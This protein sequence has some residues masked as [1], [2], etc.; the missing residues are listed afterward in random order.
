M[1]LFAALVS[2]VASVASAAYHEVPLADIKADSKL[3][4]RLLSKARR[5][6]QEE[7]E[8]NWDEE[9]E[10]RWISGYSIKF[11]GCHHISQWNKE[12]EDEEDVRIVTKR[13]VRFRLCPTDYCVGDDSSGCSS[14]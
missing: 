12:A 13:L 5:A 14:E 10:N 11:Q 3:G 4:A 7:E 1:K 9:M 2:L 6:E 8:Y